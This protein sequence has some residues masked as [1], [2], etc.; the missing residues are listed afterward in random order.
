MMECLGLISMVFLDTMQDVI[1]LSRN[2]WAFM[3]RSM[4]AD[5]PYSEVV[6]THGESAMRL[7]T[8]TFSTLSPRTSFISFVKG[9]NSAF[10]SSIFF[11]SSSSSMSRPSLVVDFSFLPSNSFNCCTPYSSMGS[12][13][14]N[15]SSP[16]LRKLPK[17][18][19]ETQ[20]QHFHQ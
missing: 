14:Y 2:A 20:Q 19:E 7:L 11:F 18:G 16:F 1:E 15:T 6:S 9:S 12:T 10:I 4:L 13:M 8:S 17:K 3:I 5:Q